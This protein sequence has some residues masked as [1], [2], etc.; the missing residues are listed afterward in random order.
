MSLFSVT[1]CVPEFYMISMINSRF[2]AYY[3]DSFVNST[4]HCTTGD[5]KLIPIFIP[6]IEQLQNIKEIFDKAIIIR[7]KESNNF[8]SVQEA[9]TELDIIQNDLDS[10]VNELYGI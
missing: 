4:S 7:E 5:A 3:I 9:E 6:T 10:I 8:L 1:E 2:V